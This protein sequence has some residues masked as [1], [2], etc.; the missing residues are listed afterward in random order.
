MQ[1]EHSTSF[2][3]CTN[4]VPP[5]PVNV[6]ATATSGSSITVTWTP[7]VVPA[8][9][10]PVTAY[11]VTAVPSSGSTVQTTSSTT[12]TELSGLQEDTTYTIQVVA[13]NA[14]GSSSAGTTRARTFIITG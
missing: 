10:A 1:A 7:P 13:H 4:A 6:T 12:S 2:S 8:N 14:I 5:P 11:T 3:R 9:G